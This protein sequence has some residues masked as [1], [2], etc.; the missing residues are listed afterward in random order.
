[1]SAP[2]LQVDHAVA[3]R[4]S[5]GYRK[6]LEIHAPAFNLGGAIEVHMVQR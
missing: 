1:M 4:V 6:L 3:C 2:N 5:P